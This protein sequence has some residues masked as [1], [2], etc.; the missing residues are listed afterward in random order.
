MDNIV[1]HPSANAIR[2]PANL[3]IRTAE[4]AFK[5]LENLW[6]ERR[7]TADSYVIDASKAK[8]QSDFIQDLRK[9]N[10]EVILD[11]KCAELS[12]I[13]R[14]HGLPKGAP[15]SQEDRPLGVQDFSTHRGAN[16]AIFGSITQ[17][18]LE[19]GVTA[20]S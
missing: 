11:T 19:M 18:A 6:A 5:K 10:S 14:Y 1:D 20:D 3:S 13:G 15:W 9:A 17:F 16:T 8:F 7:L 12:V 4:T 2:Q